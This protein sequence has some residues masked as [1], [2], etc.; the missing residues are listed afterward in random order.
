MYTLIHIKFLYYVRNGI[1]KKL[2]NILGFTPSYLNPKF[3][4]SVIVRSYGIWNFASTLA[5][6]ILYSFGM[7][8]GETVSELF[9]PSWLAVYIRVVYLN[10]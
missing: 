5:Y 1:L 8:I 4:R 7:K 2:L 10:P 6:D 9:I 3:Q